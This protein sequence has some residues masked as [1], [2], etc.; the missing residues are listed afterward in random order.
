MTQPL[1]EAQHMQF[2]RRSIRLATENVHAAGGPFGAVIV[3]NG[4]IVAEGVN[5][6]TAN[7]DPTAHAE[8]TAIR[9]AC[10]V[11]QRFDLRGAT[12]YTS[13]EP[14]PMCL[15]AAYWARL[16][17][18][19]FAAD[20]FQAA[21][22]GFDDAWLYDEVVLPYEKRHIPIRRMLQGEAMQPFAAWLAKDD[23]THY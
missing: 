20:R 16:D 3:H 13:C 18:V 15:T 8:V 2:L 14:C 9:Q 17:A 10:Q 1:H 12:L 19:F 7:L 5:R 4:Q 22:G 6:V 21:Q 23:R 11:L